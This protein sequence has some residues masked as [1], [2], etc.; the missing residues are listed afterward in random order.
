MK[1]HLVKI[2]LILLAAS[3]NVW[4]QDISFDDLYNGYIPSKAAVGAAPAISSAAPAPT[5]AAA[6]AATPAKGPYNWLIMVFINGRNNLWLQGV[7]DVNEMEKIGST[8]KVAV[9]VELGVLQDRKTSS[10]MFIKK[11][12]NNPD[13][14]QDRAGG[15]HYMDGT[16]IKTAR[17]KDVFATLKSPS[18]S[19]K[20]S[21]MGSWKHAV[22]FARWAIRKYPAQKYALILWNHGSGRIDIGGADNTG[23]ELGIA[24]DD[25]TGNF[26]R[27]SQIARMLDEISKIAGKKLDVYASDAC[28]MQMLSVIYEIKDHAGIIVQ[29]EEIVPGAGFPYDSILKDLTSNPNSQ[30]VQ[31]ARIITKNFDRYYE[32]HNRKHG[33]TISAVNPGA[34]GKLIQKLNAWISIA[35]KSDRKKILSAIKETLSFEHGYTGNDTTMH[36]RSK[37]LYDFIDRVNKK[38]DKKSPLFSA[39]EELKKSIEKAAFYNETAGPVAAYARAKG[40]AVYFPKLIY[41][42]SYDEMLS[43]R[44]SLWDDFIKWILDESYQVRQ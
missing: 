34:L 7:N 17:V 23:A 21:D 40:I 24:Y 12:N 37:D 39:G 22:S 2:F 9:V 35:V 10:R 31:L 43:S 28:L 14:F 33:T 25:L 16:N 44:D 5:P 19:I 3:L 20:N 6:A 13:F 8:D 11:D 4:T 27:N 41:D 18:V 30:A 32:V 1:Q 29:S 42:S 26:I 38:I 36:A 15:I